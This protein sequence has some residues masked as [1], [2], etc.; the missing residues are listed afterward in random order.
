M[1]QTTRVAAAQDALKTLID[2]DATLGAIK[3]DLGAPTSIQKPDHLWIAGEVTDWRQQ[4]V[5]TTTGP[6]SVREEFF[7][8]TVEIWVTKTADAYITAR[9]R[10]ITLMQALEGVIRANATLTSN[11]RHADIADVS[12]H[13]AFADHERQMNIRVRVNCTADLQA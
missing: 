6:S 4:V 3:T 5:L 11:V 7:T 1:A 12:M 9:D 8:L 10:A 13:E 2:A